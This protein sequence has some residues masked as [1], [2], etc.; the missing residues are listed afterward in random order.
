MTRVSL[1]VFQRLQ[2]YRGDSKIC[3]NTPFPP[4]IRQGTLA[5]PWLQGLI[6]MLLMTAAIQALAANPPD[7]HADLQ[8][9]E[10]RPFAQQTV[11]LRLRVSHSPA[12]TELKVDP[13]QATNFTLRLMASPPRTTR[14][15]GPQQ[16]T[17]DF[18]YALT[19]LAS[20]ALRIPS[21]TVRARLN[22]ATPANAQTSP[23]EISISSEPLNL[24]VRALPDDA[25]A[26]LPLYALDVT[27]QYDK[28]RR[29]QVGVPVEVSIVQSAAGG[30][31]ERLS[32]ATSLIKSDDF[33]V[34]PG[35][36]ETSN[37]LMRNGQLLLGQR[38]DTLTLVPLHDGRLQLPAISLPWWDI[39]RGRAAQASWPV[40]SLEIWPEAGA[41]PAPTAVPPQPDMTV[42]ARAGM[43]LP[44]QVV[45]GMIFAFAAG[46][47]LHGRCLRGE[48]AGAVKPTGGFGLLVQLRKWA[49]KA[50]RHGIACCM[51]VPGRLRRRQRTI[52]TLSGAAL[53]R[54][55]QTL[56]R[57]A[58]RLP[59]PWMI[60]H[61][62]DHLGKAIEAAPDA[63]ALR[64]CL[65]GW[66]N[67]ILGLPIHA[68]L[69]ELG[70]TLV[71]AYPQVDGERINHLLAELDASLYGGA[72]ALELEAWKQSFRTELERIGGR[73]PFHAVPVRYT[74]LPV[75]NPV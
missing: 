8:L 31:G 18:V 72:R 32:N 45:I 4:S 10:T 65:L 62:T 15:S 13:V 25:Q 47:W 61:E 20:G 21:M 11:M 27:L 73:K 71:R 68:T 24:D 38:I 57:I 26:L 23:R 29:P 64:Q 33:R 5:P 49:L 9:D 69:A 22:S 1:P 7:L 42:A 70:K 54:Q 56:G 12:V 40:E 14:M 37:R 66:G 19:P 41:V 6:A 28:R 55:A 30:A 53:H 59:N 44:W 75:L 48:T 46:W 74:G 34:Y 51:A 50:G 2:R 67:R 35:K 36:S 63:D 58:E 39:G 60:A 16:L 52:A 3:R 43:A 17:S